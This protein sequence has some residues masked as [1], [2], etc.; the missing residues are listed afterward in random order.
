MGAGKCFNRRLL[1]EYRIREMC[2]EDL[3]AVTAL[4]AACFSMPWKYHDFENIL[5]DPKC[6]YLV[7]VLETE[8]RDAQLPTVIGG[9]LL[10]DTI[11]EG[12]ISNVAVHADF[13]KN[14]IATALLQALLTIGKTKREIK[15]FTLEV[16]SQNLAAIGLYQKLGFISVGI[17][18]RFYEKPKDDALIMKFYIESERQENNA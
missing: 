11:G 7:A 1:M 2:K 16:R 6:I 3:E 12:D 9:C 14:H 4:E 15:V 17:R 18:P 8:K 13:R 5:S 10:I